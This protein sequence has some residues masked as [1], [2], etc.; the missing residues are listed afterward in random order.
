MPTQLARL[1]GQLIVAGYVG[2][3]PTSPILNAL[4]Q[5]TRAGAILFKR[6]APTWQAALNATT[7]LAR[8][9]RESDRDSISPIIA[10][11]QE[12]GRVQRLGP[13]VLQLPPARRFAAA[14]Q[15]ANH[16]DSIKEPPLHVRAARTL[17]SQLI[18]LGFNVNFAPVLD[19]DTNPE[20][21]V[22]GDRSFS[23]NPETVAQLGVEF[24][25]GL[26]HAGIAA[27]G[28]HFPGHGD[29][30]LDS[31]VAL[32][33]VDATIQRLHATE[34]V[35]FVA[36]SKAGIAAMMT[37]H[38]VVPS[39]DPESPATMSP[40]IIRGLLREQMGFDGVIFSDDLEMHAISMRY[41]IGYAAV[42]AV[43][44]GCDVLLICKHEDFQN[45]AHEAL[46]HEAELAPTFRSVCEQAAHRCR[47]LRERY[48][49]RDAAAC[50]ETNPI[51][52]DP[53]TSGLQETLD[54]L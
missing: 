36:A 34:L 42:Q 51:S 46:I 41:G 8:A 3:S 48:P 12:G 23:H 14:A 25:L 16:G 44:A 49:V 17:G 26:Q 15:H 5:G 37:A 53:S 10:V 39:L 27:C 9:A 2:D 4:K 18:Q 31:H 29:T 43:R 30:S 6:N 22:I 35:P 54:S 32:P 47:S 7:M 50:T 13:P 40:T 24:A 28:K 19:V 1:C 11:D 21:P 45:E 33:T 38:I 20:N 52:I